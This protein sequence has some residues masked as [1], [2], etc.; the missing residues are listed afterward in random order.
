M[1]YSGFSSLPPL[2][3]AGFPHPF[4]RAWGNNRLLIAL[5]SSLA[6][7]IHSPQCGHDDLSTHSSDEVIIWMCVYVWGCGHIHKCST[8]CRGGGRRALGPWACGD[9]TWG[10]FLD[11][12]PFYILNFSI[13]FLLSCACA[14]VCVHV[15]VREQFVGSW[16]SPS[17]MGVLVIKCK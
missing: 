10:I 4:F 12:S 1:S 5:T 3:N 14:Y 9:Q 17:T 15:E 7:S 11:F 2:S 13:L 16:S 8:V 6:S